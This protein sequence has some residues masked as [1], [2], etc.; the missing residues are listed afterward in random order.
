MSPIAANPASTTVPA[1]GVY[2]DEWGRLV[3]IDANGERHI[4]VTACRLFPFTDPER[5]LSVSDATGNELLCV[6][7]TSDLSPAVAEILIEAAMQ[8]E[9]VPVI[10]RIISVSG[11]TEPC[12]W[13]V[14]TDRG[15]T[16]LVLKSEED[17]RRLDA[18]QAMIVD[19]SGQRYLVTDVQKM[20]S[21][22]R[23]QLERYV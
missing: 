14:E 20:D 1:F 9:F 18:R 23:R 3:L 13:L 22:S 12:E 16:T 6:E 8:R 11:V 21:L 7:K 19:G 10:R 2:R 17:V 4:D 15:T 5:W